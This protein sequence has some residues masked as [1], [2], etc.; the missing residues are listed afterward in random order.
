[1]GSAQT[2]NS[3]E[4]IANISNFVDNSTTVNSNAVNDVKNRVEVT[5]CHLKADD[6]NIETISKS[7]QK[8]NQIVKA[9]QD[10]NLNNNIQQKMLQESLSKVGSLGIGFANASNSTTVIA[11][12]SNEIINAMNVASNQYSTVHNNFNCNNSTILAKN[13]NIS[14]ESYGSF[15][16]EQTLKNDQ[17]A[18]I[19][20][21]ISQSVD[22]KATA[23]VEGISGMIIL[24][25][26]ALAVLVY[27]AMK[28]LSSGGGKII[29][30]VLMC[31][32]IMIVLVGM[33]I[34]GTPPFFADLDEC[35]H[36]SSLGTGGSNCTDYTQR[37]IKLSSAPIKYLYGIT[38]FDRSQPGANLVQMSIAA[39]SGQVTSSGVNGGYRADTWSNLETSLANYTQYAQN[40]NIPMIPNPLVVPQKTADNAT[41][42][43]LIP[44]EYAGNAAELKS[45]GL[46]T[47]GTVQVGIDSSEK[48]LSNCPQFAAP[49]A[50]TTTSDFGT[51]KDIVANLNNADWQDYI[52]MTGRFPPSPNFQGYDEALTRALFARFVLCDMIGNIDLHYYISEDEYIRF[53]DNNNNKVIKLARNAITENPED[54]YMYHPYILPGSPS[55]GIISS[56]YID[57]YVGYVDNNKYRYQVFMRN[58]GVYICIGI[59]VFILL[60]MFYLWKTN[61]KEKKAAAAAATGTGTG[62]A[63]G[64]ATPAPTQ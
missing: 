36:N 32:L 20:N 34:R 24:L 46:C 16:S 13:I 23:E 53:L 29:V 2:K 40:L 59:I 33:Y 50:F 45:N 61:K 39:K 28:P 9:K 30:G 6:I 12:S 60:F 58:T 17:V 1:M 49:E 44:G 55:D 11:N 42:Y 38:P 48:K 21:E 64:T 4:V 57:G 62:T 18:A 25:L 8:N 26:I 15:L 51:G 43:Y 27:V 41:N 3:S 52:N 54:V 22:Q 35:I 63:T 5:T 10:A 56:G 14:Y 47:P 31:F 37:K 19:T 7:V